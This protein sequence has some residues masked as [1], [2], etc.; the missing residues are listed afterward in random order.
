MPAV[1]ETVSSKPERCLRITGRVASHIH[2]AEQQRLDLIAYI[3]RAQLLEE[4]GEEVSRVVEQDVDSAEL[5]DGGVDCRVRVLWAGDVESDCQQVVVVAQRRHDLRR[6]AAGGNNGVTGS[7]GGLGSVDAQTSTS[8]GNKTK[9]P[10]PS[11]YASRGCVVSASVTSV[12]CWQGRILKT[13]QRNSNG[14]TMLPASCCLSDRASAAGGSRRAYEF[15]GP[16][17][18][19]G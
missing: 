11:S 9:L 8:S 15:D 5:R 13:G 4:A 1:E 12:P 18:A 19:G 10:L 17:G 2:R 14:A 3:F 7:Q 16:P 6:I